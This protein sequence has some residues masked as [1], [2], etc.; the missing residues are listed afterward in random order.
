[1]VGLLT[2]SLV[3][4]G[5]LAVV[6]GGGAVAERKVAALL[7]GGARV[8]VVSPELTPGLAALAE[9]GRVEAVRRAWAPGDGSGA[10]LVIAATG[11]AAV[12]AAAAAEARAAGQLVNVA[13]EPRLGNIHFTAEV[14]R[15]PLRIAVASDGSAPGLVRRLREELEAQ[16]VP[17][18]GELASLVGQARTRLRTVPRLTAAERA[19]LLDELMDKAMKLR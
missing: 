9:A 3:T 12:D 14:R 2:V 18:W 5:Q 19:Q 7:D 10:L 1:M 16:V 17:E 13:S 11:D 6:V 8:R 15:G 4:A